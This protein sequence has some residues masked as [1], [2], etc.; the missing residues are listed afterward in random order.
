LR[1][2]IEAIDRSIVERLAARVQLARAVGRAKREA[3]LPTLDGRREAAVERYAAAMAQAAD[4]PAEE[5][6]TIFQRVIGLCRQV[7]LEET[8][9]E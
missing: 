4:L 8:E 1:A 6:Q 5:V 2:E 9:A 7:Q 3:G